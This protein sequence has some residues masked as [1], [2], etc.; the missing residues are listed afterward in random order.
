V[1]VG[2]FVI[3]FPEDAGHPVLPERD[4][5]GHN[6][7]VRMLSVQFVSPNRILPLNTLTLSAAAFEAAMAARAR[8]AATSAQALAC[9]GLLKLI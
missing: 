5:S 1:H 4:K 6:V 2:R 3:L 9:S 7:S 8:E